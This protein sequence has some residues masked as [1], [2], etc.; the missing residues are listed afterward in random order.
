VENFRI[1]VNSIEYL[2]SRYSTLYFMVNYAQTFLTASIR[3][4]CNVC[5]CVC[6]CVSL[7]VSVYFHMSCCIK[8]LRSNDAKSTGTINKGMK[9]GKEC[10]WNVYNCI[11]VFWVYSLSSILLFTQYCCLKKHTFPR[12]P[13]WAYPVRL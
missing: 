11:R 9:V 6:V 13:K 12:T 8:F 5:V 7:L 4:T 1:V 3:P 10:F 2:Y